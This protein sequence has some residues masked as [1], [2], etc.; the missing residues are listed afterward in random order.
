MLKKKWFKNFS[1]V[2]ALLVV[3]YLFSACISVRF[4]RS[5]NPIRSAIAVIQVLFTD[6]NYAQVQ[7]YPEQNF[8]IK[9][10]NYEKGAQ[11]LAQAHLNGFVEKPEKQLGSM[12]YFES[13][14]KIAI[15]IINGNKYYM[16]CSIEYFNK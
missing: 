7:Q 15:V 16:R 1:V 5:L 9:T 6:T 3:L 4:F 2:L 11:E 8:L 14:D 10:A 13:E 12:K